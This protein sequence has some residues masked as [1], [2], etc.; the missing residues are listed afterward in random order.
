M[1]HDIKLP[2]LGEETE[3]SAVVTFWL[4]KL[5]DEVR[6]GDDLVE[7]STDKAAFTLPSP[8]RGRLVET[9]VEEGDEV[10]VG[11]VLCV[12]ES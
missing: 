5:D 4:V 9:L 12:L 10:R 3:D 7:L 2:S 6:K 8:R 11:D 1:R